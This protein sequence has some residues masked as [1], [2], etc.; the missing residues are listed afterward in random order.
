M[1]ELSKQDAERA[2]RAAGLRATGPRIFVLRLLAETRRPLSHS[3]VVKKVGVGQWDPATIYRNLV[4]LVEVGLIRVASTAEGITRYESRKAGEEAHV[5]PHFTC[6]KC[7]GVTCLPGAILR[8]EVE[9][10][11][12]EALK[13]AELQL[14][15]KCPGCRRSS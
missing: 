11:W 15:G 6:K 14:I 3:E 8:G 7:G 4:K 9:H 12:I 13:D 5:H 10:A 2:L 1:T